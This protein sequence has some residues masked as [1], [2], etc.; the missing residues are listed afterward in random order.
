MYSQAANIVILQKLIV[1][2][3]GKKGK[4]QVMSVTADE[5]HLLWMYQLL[6]WLS[7]HFHL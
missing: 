5:N 6:L 7:R 4:I 1:T 3:F 2:R